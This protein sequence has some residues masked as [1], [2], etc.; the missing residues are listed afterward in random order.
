MIWVNYVANQA[1]Q[2]TETIQAIKTYVSLIPATGTF[3]LALVLMLFYNLDKDQVQ[4]IKETLKTRREE[5]A[6]N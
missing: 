5:L 1:T 4:H 6:K 3:V 2:T